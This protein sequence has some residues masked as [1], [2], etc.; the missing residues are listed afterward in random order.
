[1]A[2]DNIIVSLCKQFTEMPCWGSCRGAG[3][4][5]QLC[6]GAHLAELPAREP[7]LASQAGSGRK[8]GLKIIPLHFLAEVNNKRK[9]KNKERQGDAK[10]FCF[11]RSAFSKISCHIIAPQLSCECSVSH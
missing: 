2:K 5:A 8:T 3:E 10:Y 4:P 11:E 6:A 7:Q 9:K 1:M